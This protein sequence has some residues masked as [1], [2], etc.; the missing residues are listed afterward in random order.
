MQRIQTIMIAIAVVAFAGGCGGSDGNGEKG[1]YQL[2]GTAVLADGGDHSGIKIRV[3]E[4]SSVVNTQ[5]NG[6]FTLPDLADGDW[7]LKASREF[8][9]TLT[10]RLRVRGGLLMEPIGELTLNRTLFMYVRSDSLKYTH[11]S[12]SVDIWIVLKNEDVEQLDLF[13]SF[14]R[15]YDFVITNPVEGDE[16]IWQWSQI[17]PPINDEKFDFEE[18]IAAKDSLKLSPHRWWN[19]KESNGTP[20]GTGTFEIQGTIDLQDIRRQWWQFK[21]EKHVIKLVP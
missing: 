16:I 2:A 1:T 4:N 17:R 6:S 8:Y 12:D 7:T 3:V 13:S 14:F 20:A 18:T 5:A 15:P 21:S 11:K 19:K 10:L 9:S